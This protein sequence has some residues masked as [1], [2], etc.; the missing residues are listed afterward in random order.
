MII[1]YSV[2]YSYELILNSRIKRKFLSEI[3]QSK[4]IYHSRGV[5]RTFMKM[6]P[7]NRI[8]EISASYKIS[9][10]PSIRLKKAWMFGELAQ[11]ND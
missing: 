7:A 5:A 1:K 6:K 10:A 9:C 8:S 3:C 11:S 2:P 4:F